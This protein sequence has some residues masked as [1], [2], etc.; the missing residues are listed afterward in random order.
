MATHSST[1]AWKIPWMQ[2][3]PGRPQSTASQRLSCDWAP[4]LSFFLTLCPQHWR[5]SPTSCHLYAVMLRFWLDR[6]PEFA[7]T[8]RCPPS[9]ADHCGELI[10]FCLVSSS[11]PARVKGSPVWWGWFS[12]LCELVMHSYPLLIRYLDTGR[13]VLPGVCF[14]NKSIGNTVQMNSGRRESSH[15]HPHQKP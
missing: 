10:N 5:S 13:T 8:A 14:E 7:L 3:E 2:E 6:N 11:L 9:I 12:S 4:S 15:V 1:L